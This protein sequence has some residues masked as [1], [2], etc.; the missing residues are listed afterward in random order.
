MK[1]KINPVPKKEFKKKEK[2]Y[3]PIKPIPKGNFKKMGKVTKK[4]CK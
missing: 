4:N 2:M 3:A 1:S